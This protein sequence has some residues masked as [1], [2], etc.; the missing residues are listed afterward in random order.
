MQIRRRRAREVAEEF[1]RDLRRAFADGA[2]GLE[3]THTK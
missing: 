2:A 3:F 1:E